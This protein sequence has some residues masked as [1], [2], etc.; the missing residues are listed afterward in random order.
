VRDRIGRVASC[1]RA[2]VVAGLPK[3]R[4]GT[5]LRGTVRKIEDGEDYL[6]LDPTALE[7]N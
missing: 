6:L 5:I 3:I 4:S 2:F 1:K 7:E